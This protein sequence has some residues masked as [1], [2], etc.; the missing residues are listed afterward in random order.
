MQVQ[1]FKV[2]V[3]DPDTSQTIH[4]FT[5]TDEIKGMFPKYIH[6]T[7]VFGLFGVVYEIMEIGIDNA[8]EDQELS[9]NVNVFVKK[10]GVESDF[11]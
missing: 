3:I 7:E 8:F 6:E 1:N 9:V 5:T 11:E 2:N 4:E 10:I